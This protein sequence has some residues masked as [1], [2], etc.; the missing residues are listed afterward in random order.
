[1]AKYKYIDLQTGDRNKFWG[2]PVRQIGYKKKKLG[3]GKSPPTGDRKMNSSLPVSPKWP[4]E[5]IL[6]LG[7]FATTPGVVSSGNSLR[8]RSGSPDPPQEIPGIFRIDVV[9]VRDN[10]VLGL[11]TSKLQKF[12]VFR[13]VFF[14]NFPDYPP[15]PVRNFSRLPSEHFWKRRFLHHSRR[16]RRRHDPCPRPMN[17]VDGGFHH[18]RHFHPDLP[19]SSLL[20]ISSATIAR[21]A[22]KKINYED[23]F[24]QGLAIGK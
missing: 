3:T 15:K 17:I 13:P 7:E 2:V 16:S 20:A 12:R 6:K 8:E 23:G 5:N 24:R 4:Q 21:S 1:L 19:L 10:A 14:R 11:K 18:F 22:S 9:L